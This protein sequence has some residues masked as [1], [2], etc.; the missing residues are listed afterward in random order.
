MSIQERTPGDGH[1]A[2]W[3]DVSSGWAP[4]LDLPAPLEYG[5]LEAEAP[6]APTG[7]A[8]EEPLGAA[9]RELGVCLDAA[10]S[11]QA[12]SE[13]AR[14]HAAAD[15]AATHLEVARVAAELAAERGRVAQLERDRD[16][17]IRRAE[18]LVTAVRERADQRLAAELEADRR[19]WQQLLAEERRRAEVLEG[20][21]AALV[22]QLQESLQPGATVRRPR[23]LRPP[24][25]DDEAVSPVEPSLV[26]VGGPA[27]NS[28]TANSDTAGDIERLRERLRAQLHRPPALADVEAGVDRLRESRLERESEGRRRHK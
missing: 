2:P 13:A 1:A 6:P 3:L 18:E 22:H 27:A 12:A 19:H 14:Q 24:S 5:V 7:P 28:G 23:P 11:Q 25:A 20:E 26:A 17:V 10:R 21:R 16:D 9:V 4:M 15:A 8:A